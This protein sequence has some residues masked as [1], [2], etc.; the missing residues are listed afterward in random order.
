MVVESEYSYTCYLDKLNHVYHKTVEHD[1]CCWRYQG[2]GNDSCVVH[3]KA[4]VVEADCLH[5]STQPQTWD[6]VLVNDRNGNQQ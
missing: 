3:S 1:D 2:V 4:P 5:N 6:N